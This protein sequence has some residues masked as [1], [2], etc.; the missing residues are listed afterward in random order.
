MGEETTDSNRGPD[1]DTLAMSVMLDLHDHIA[2]QS[3]QV[4]NVRAGHGLRKGSVEI[5]YIILSPD[6]VSATG[7]V[8][9]EGGDSDG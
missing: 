6:D 4:L 2:R 8:G 3:V 7:N 9:T 1:L 5:E